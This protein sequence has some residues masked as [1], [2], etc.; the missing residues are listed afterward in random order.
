MSP[1]LQRVIARPLHLAQFIQPGETDTDSSRPERRLREQFRP[2]IRSHHD[3]VRT[4]EA[5]WCG[6][7]H[8][9]AAISWTG[10]GQL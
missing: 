5:Y 10:H 4:Q 1:A 6:M 2:V 8:F 7:L 9:I 3:S